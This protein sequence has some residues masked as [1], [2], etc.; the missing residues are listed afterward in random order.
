[1]DV[2]RDNINKRNHLHVNRG[3]IN[4]SKLCTGTETRYTLK[5]I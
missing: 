1:M 3:L 2:D 5:N 4:V